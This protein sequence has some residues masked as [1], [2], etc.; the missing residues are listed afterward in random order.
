MDPSTIPL[1]TLLT[2]SSSRRTSR[3]LNFAPFSHDN[4]NSFLDSRGMAE[5]DGVGVQ[6][7]SGLDPPYRA[8]SSVFGYT[9]PALDNLLIPITG[10]C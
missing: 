7:L 8:Q 1:A 10:P 4:L 2:L 6:H 5:I 3:L 9:V